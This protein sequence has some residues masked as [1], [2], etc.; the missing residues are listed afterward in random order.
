[1]DKW[2]GIWSARLDVLSVHLSGKPS[3]QL[4]VH[5]SVRELGKRSAL[6][7]VVPSGMP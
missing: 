5:R 7:L 2:L 4:L 3:V 6:E 1:M